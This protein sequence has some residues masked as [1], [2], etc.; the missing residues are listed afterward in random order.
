MQARERALEQA[1]G[2]ITMALVLLLIAGMMI[3][4]MTAVLSSEEASF[5]SE[6]AEVAPAALSSTASMPR[7]HVDAGL[8]LVSIT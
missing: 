2:L 1:D 3:V 5:S 4:A 7:P 8:A 6:D